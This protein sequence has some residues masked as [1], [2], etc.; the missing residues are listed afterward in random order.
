MKKILIIGATSAIA[1]ECARL[2]AAEKASFFL[3]ARN[4]EKLQ[5]VANDLTAR[6]ATTVTTCVLDVNQFNQH[7][8]MLE[9]CYAALGQIDIVLIAHGTL[10]NQIKC[11]HDVNLTLNEFS[12]NCLSIIAMLTPLANYMEKQQYGTIAVISSVAGDRGRAFYVYSTAKAAVSCFCDGLRVRLF[13]SGVNVL[14]IKPGYVDTPMTQGL[15]L[16]QLLVAKP[17]KVAKDILNAIKHKRNTLYTP[18]FWLFV[19]LIIKSIPN[20]IFKRL[21]I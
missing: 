11:E 8:F 14:T 12:T 5:Q 6:G 17:Q 20:C 21:K 13:K 2:W 10:S 7:H 15:Q 18:W 4:A 16:P 19:M 1:D 3:V 9:A